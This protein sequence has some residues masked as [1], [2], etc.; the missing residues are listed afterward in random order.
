[1][2]LQ[3]AKKWI[4]AL[5]SGKYHQARGQLWKRS[6]NR[7][8]SYCCLGVLTDLYCKEKGVDRLNICSGE[9]A[10]L[11]H[12]VVEWAEMKT[13]LGRIPNK[14]E[15]LANANDGDGLSSLNLPP[16]NFKEIAKL[17][18]KYKKEL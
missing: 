16:L 6:N 2:N 5:K 12:K 17:I 10:E 3:I 14:Y 7:H 11:S 4:T 9:D 15:T 18:N 13:E 1:M 8:Y